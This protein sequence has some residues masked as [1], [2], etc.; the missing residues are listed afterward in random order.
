VYKFMKTVQEYVV[1]VHVHDNM[2]VWTSEY[3][4]DIHMAPGSGTVDLSVV[5][6]LGFE[7]IHNLEVFTM[8]DVITGK[9]IL[10]AF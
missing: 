8:E 9:E 5:E 4:G 3:N 6:E 1:H 7:G 2:G 10:L